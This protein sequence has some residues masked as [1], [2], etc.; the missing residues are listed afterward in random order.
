MSIKL[1]NLFLQIYK[2]YFVYIYIY[3]MYIHTQLHIYIYVCLILHIHILHFT[4]WNI[5][6][7][8]YIYVH[9]FDAWVNESGITQPHALKCSLEQEHSRNH[10]NILL[11]PFH[12]VHIYIYIWTSVDKRTRGVSPMFFMTHSDFRA[13]YSSCAENNLACWPIGQFEP[14]FCRLIPTC[15]GSMSCL[16][17]F[18]GTS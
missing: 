6:I 18:I 15:E 9:R 11:R 10:Q 2:Q 14:L 13:V 12:V 17:Q 5:Y 3:A 4:Y 16:D 1:C 7:Y 8:I